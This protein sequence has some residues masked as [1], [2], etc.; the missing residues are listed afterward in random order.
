MTKRT[1]AAYDRWS[2]TYDA[3]GNPQILMEHDDVLALVD[4][5][6]DESILDAACGT[7]KYTSE[8]H[9]AGATVIG[10]DLSQA[11]LD[12]A[13]KKHPKLSLRF[14]DLS[15]RLPFEDAA[16]DKVNC[17]QALKHLPDLPVVFAEIARVLRPDGVFVFSVTHPDMFWDDYEINSKILVDIK[18]EADLYHHRFCDYFHALERTGF[19]L[20]RLVQ[21]A[22]SDKIKHLLTPESYRKV[23]GRY[24][25][26]A[27]RSR[28]RGMTSGSA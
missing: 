21:I 16:F 15:E 8:F 24:Q 23:N 6:P 26:L 5:H 3:E 22:V 2:Q 7:G 14:A 9:K 28:K 13:Q 12:R 20:D 25:V 27:V 19:K 11:M 1:Q 4:A 10:I 17:A 18:V